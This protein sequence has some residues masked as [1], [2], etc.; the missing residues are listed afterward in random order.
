M[1]LPVA[2]PKRHP[3]VATGR[4]NRA[5]HTDGDAKRRPRAAIR[6]R[7]PVDS[8]FLPVWTGSYRPKTL[9]RSST[10]CFSIGPAGWE[11]TP[12]GIWASSVQFDGTSKAVATASSMS[13]L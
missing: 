13:G 6:R 2:T 3:R 8:S 9:T 12:N 10:G 11:T 4:R 5:E 7:A 1:G